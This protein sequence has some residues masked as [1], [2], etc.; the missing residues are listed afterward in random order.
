MPVANI[1]VRKRWSAD[2]QQFLIGALHAA[3]VE[4]LK[5]PE[6]DRKIRYVEHRPEHF[7]VPPQASENYTLVEISLFPGRSLETKRKLYRGIV[8]RFG[9]IGI[10]PGDILD[11]MRNIDLSPLFLTA[12]SGHDPVCVAR[13]TGPASTPVQRSFVTLG[14]KSGH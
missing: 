9:E 7:A 13:L 3:M 14:D 1:E 4:A 5:I 6:A 10:A 12:A 8:Q 2:Q 11:P